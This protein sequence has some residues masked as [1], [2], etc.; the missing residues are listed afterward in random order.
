MEEGT[1]PEPAS[2]SI[3]RLSDSEARENDLTL[4]A[5]YPPNLNKHGK[6]R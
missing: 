6:V 2:Y 5:F 4:S 1:V 3:P